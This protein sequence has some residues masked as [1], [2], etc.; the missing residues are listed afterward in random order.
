MSSGEN[1][2]KD[3]LK[4]YVIGLFI[5][6]L[7]CTSLVLF[8]QNNTLEE[9]SDTKFH[10]EYTSYNGKETSNGKIYPEVSI[11]KENLYYYISEDE[12]KDLFLNG[13]GVLYLG[14]PTCPW[15]RNI[16]SVLN[17]A[18]KDYG[19]AKI[20]YYN[21]K[22]IRSNYS[23]DDANKLV[24]TDGS[25]LYTYLLEKLDSFLEDY[26]IQDNDGKE[27]Q[28]G[29][30]R[31]YAPTVVFIKNGEIKQVI[32][33]TVDSQKDPYILLND[34]QKEELKNKYLEAFNELAD[35]CGEK[36]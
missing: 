14:F 23:F 30:K 36:C 7:V 20:N 22:E 2:K 15:C 5:I 27:I 10:D 1:M 32:E 24:K 19:I 8:K 33:G 12:I 17:E 16:V 6:C 26:T 34:S 35:L 31:I 21:I 18:G 29:E 9:K 28:T 25:T 4:Y 13:T 3:F 11:D